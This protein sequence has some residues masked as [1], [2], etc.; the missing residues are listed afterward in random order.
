MVASNR[1]TCI[2]EC[3]K[4]EGGYSNL[5]AD[6]GGAT[7]W[8]ITIGDARRYWKKDAT[9]A[10]VK[11]M[12]KSV[13]INI[14]TTKYWKT[15]QY[16]CDKLNAGVDLVVFDTGVLCGPG[17]AK[18]FLDASI[19]SQNDA[20]TINKFMDQRLAFLK[21]L[22]TWSTFG[23]GWGRRVAGIRSKALEMA[24]AKP[25]HTGTIVGGTI[26]GGAVAATHVH[27][28]LHIAEIA[29]ATILGALAV[30]LIVKYIKNR[31]QNV[32]VQ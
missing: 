6:L 28:W 9:P 21:S 8:G 2:T 25:G 15:P 20:D 3:L 7:N 16:D 31:K 32:I 23:T 17:K 24:K 18:K 12:P 22:K 29:S 30:Y 1:E 5:A 11:A 10:D 13:A 14:Y 27:N 4:W 26:A 19:G